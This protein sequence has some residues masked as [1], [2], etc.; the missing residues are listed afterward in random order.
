MGLTAADPKCQLIVEGK[1]SAWIKK[2]RLE[3]WDITVE[4]LPE[5]EFLNEHR[6]LI[7]P[8]FFIIP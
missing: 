6:G 5:T 4:L 8:L 1:L 3:N 7:N 2:M